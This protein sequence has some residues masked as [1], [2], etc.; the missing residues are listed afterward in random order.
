MLDDGLEFHER[1][2]LIKTLLTKK[3]K[4]TQL[5]LVLAVWR[6]YSKLP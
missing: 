6:T 1:S 5:L 4:F 2:F 3:L